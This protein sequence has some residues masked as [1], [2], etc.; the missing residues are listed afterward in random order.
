MEHEAGNSPYFY[1]R[2]HQAVGTTYEHIGP[3]YEFVAEALKTVGSNSSPLETTS[4][5]PAPPHQTPPTNA[6]QRKPERLQD[7]L[8][9]AIRSL[10]DFDDIQHCTDWD[11]DKTPTVQLAWNEWPDTSDD[12]V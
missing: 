10:D 1:I 8:S 11:D 9:D 12:P 4:Q 3:R 6:T 5:Q 7:A 2:G